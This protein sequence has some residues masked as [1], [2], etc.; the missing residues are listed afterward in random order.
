VPTKLNGGP[1]SYE[2][3]AHCC[4]VL[5]PCATVELKWCLHRLVQ[6]LWMLGSFAMVHA[7]SESLA[8]AGS[9]Q[10]LPLHLPLPL[11]VAQY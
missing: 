4:L 8:Q 3:E 6:G 11:L 5:S 10:G 7:C 2:L 1:H 9:H